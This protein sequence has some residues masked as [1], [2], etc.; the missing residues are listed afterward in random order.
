MADTTIT[1]NVSGTPGGYFVIARY[2]EVRRAW[3]G[4][5]HH[6]DPGA[7]NFHALQETIDTQMRRVTGEH[8]HATAA[9]A[10]GA[11]VTFLLE[12]TSAIT[13]AKASGAISEVGA[14]A[15]TCAR[16]NNGLWA[17]NS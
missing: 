7:L 3:G 5:A 15:A 13:N 14:P 17:A 11:A 8:T 4:Y 2:C 12:Q 9:A 10:I 6:F 1:V 16:P